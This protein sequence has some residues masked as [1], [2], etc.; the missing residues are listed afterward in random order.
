LAT[1]VLRVAGSLAAFVVLKDRTY[2]V[3]TS[4][5][6]LLLASSLMAVVF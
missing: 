6:L 5:V 3:L 1:P 4:V 2:M